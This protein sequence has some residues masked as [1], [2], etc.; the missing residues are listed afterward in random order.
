VT[1]GEP[2]TSFRPRSAYLRHL[3]VDSGDGAVIIEPEVAGELR[4]AAALAG[5]R[6]AAGL[7]Y[8][9][10]WHD[11]DGA[12]TL[13]DGFVPAE[14]AGI[15]AAAEA[16]PVAVRASLR[17]EALRTYPGA[18]EVGWWRTAPRPDEDGWPDPGAWPLSERPDGVGL[19]VFADGTP[20]TT[21]AFTPRNVVQGSV[22]DD[23]VVDDGAVDDG[24]VDDWT[25]EELP[26]P[27]PEPEWEQELAPEPA[28]E[29]EPEPD[30]LDEP[31][32]LQSA[33]M[34]PP[35]DEGPTRGR[36]VAPVQSPQLVQQTELKSRRRH[37]SGPRERVLEAQQ[38]VLLAI[39]V[40]TLAV[41]VTV[42]VMVSTAF[43]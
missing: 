23:G 27:P 15:A 43:H 20:P 31:A 25:T 13:V 33:P 26:P 3:V 17:D 7:L 41:V 14:S 12:Y 10:L 8:G 1:A 40:L 24:V 9:H 2:D 6:P 35:W 36:S 28:P 39:V 21:A 30:V 32:V 42:G 11:D 16:D 37:E 19:V 29:P 5:R 38:W 34:P 18:E 4:M 22:V